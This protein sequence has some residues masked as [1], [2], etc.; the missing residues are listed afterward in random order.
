MYLFFV[1]IVIA[2]INL[3]TIQQLY[4]KW[5]NRLN[6][7]KIIWKYNNESIIIDKCMAWNNFILDS[8]APVIY[9]TKSTVALNLLTSSC[10]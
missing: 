1:I 6:F 5:V 7:V 10:S 2:D 3:C 9:M 4:N 8:L